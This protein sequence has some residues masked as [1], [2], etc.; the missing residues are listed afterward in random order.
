MG[1]RILMLLTVTAALAGAVMTA[2]G[3]PFLGGGL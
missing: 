1:Q 2:P 3:S